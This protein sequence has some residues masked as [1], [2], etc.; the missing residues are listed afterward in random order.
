MVLSRHRRS[1]YYAPVIILVTFLVVSGCALDELPGGDDQ[2][3][4]HERLSG[5]ISGEGEKEPDVSSPREVD[6]ADLPDLALEP[7]WAR[8]FSNRNSLS[9]SLAAQGETAAVA[10]RQSDGIYVAR[11]FDSNGEQLWEYTAP[12][13]DFVS[14]DARVLSREGRE[15]GL[16]LYSAAGTGDLRILD[17]TGT[18]QFSHSLAGMTD[19]HRSADNEVLVLLDR[20]SGKLLLIDAES[21]AELGSRKVGERAKADFVSDT[22]MLL[23]QT[24]E[25]ISI[26][27]RSAESLWSHKLDVQLR[28]DVEVADAGH[29][30]ALTTVDP[31][32]VLYVFDRSADL[33][34]KYLLLAGGSNDLLLREDDARLLVYNVG[35]EGGVFLMDMESGEAEWIYLLRPPGEDSS[36]R[37]DSAAFDS[38]GALALHVVTSEMNGPQVE[39]KH[40]LVFICPEGEIEG[41]K[42]LGVNVGVDLA[43]EG[44]ALIVASGDADPETGARV[45]DTLTYYELNVFSSSSSTLKAE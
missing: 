9:Y 21:G 23:L 20:Y 41:T 17:E 1:M 11:A 37:I 18:E 24:E 8:T 39:E 36:I 14:A 7:A 27:D 16:A 3:E 31:D 30:I 43:E 12:E 5:S 34:W 4:E 2:P 40:R 22:K 10:Y 45:L 25:K 13:R 15:V 29:K 42:V 44:G 28:G 19:F 33:L 26:A 35:A 32:N 38:E 6:L